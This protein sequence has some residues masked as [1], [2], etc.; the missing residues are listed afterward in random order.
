MAG[1]SLYAAPAEPTLKA[2]WE[3]AEDN[4]A[5]LAYRIFRSLQGREGI[6]ERERQFGEAVSVLNVQPRTAE[7]IR[8]AKDLFLE[9]LKGDDRFAGL[10]E[11]FLARLHAD[12]T[13]PRDLPTAKRFYRS[14]LERGTGDPVVETGAARLVNMTEADHPQPEDAIRALNELEPLA[15]QLKTPQGKRTFHEA[16][17]QGYILAGELEAGLRH[18]LIAESFGFTRRQTEAASWVTIAEAARELRKNDIAAEYYRKFLA[19]YLRDSRSYLIAKKLR[20]L[21]AANHQP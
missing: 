10:S 16:M 6:D 20:E 4:Q 1:A 2:A 18:H 7:N 8:Q 9:L 15:S 12:Y 19:K 17:G 5:G 13:D 21:E 11:F 3:A 14:A